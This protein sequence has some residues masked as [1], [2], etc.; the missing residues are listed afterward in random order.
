MLNLNE[1]NEAQR[2]AVMHGEGPLLVL[3]G[4]GSGKTFTITKRIQYLIEE[5]GV[6]SQQILVI[7]FTKAAAQSMQSRFQEQ[8]SQVVPFGTFHSCFYNFL[9]ETGELDPGR[10]WK[11]SKKRQILGQILSAKEG[12]LQ[13]PTNAQMDDLLSLFGYCKN[14]AVSSRVETIRSPLRH[15]LFLALP[16]NWQRDFLQ[17]FQKYEMLRR[18]AGGFD[19]DDILFDCLR[20]LEEK[21]AFRTYWQGR[22]SHIL[23]DEMQD[24]NPIQYAILK[25]LTR[26]PNNLFVVGDDDQSIYG[27]R[28]AKPECLKWFQQDF[29]PKVLVLNVNYRSSAQ[30]V[31]M[32]QQMMKE[33]KE[34]FEKKYYAADEQGT[35]QANSFFHEFTERE[36]MYNYLFGQ[37]KQIPGNETV[38][39]LFRT[40][41]LMQSCARKLHKQGIPFQMKEGGQNPYEHF[42][43]RD[44]FAY[45][46]LGKGIPAREDFLQVM[47]KPLRYLSREAL[48][49]TSFSLE[50]VGRYYEG[51]DPHGNIKKHLEKLKRQ[52]N[53]IKDL[54]LPLAV[55][56]IWKVIG[57]EYYC[58]MEA[59]NN[60]ERMEEYEELVEWL[61][62]EA[63]EYKDWAQWK[64]AAR[65]YTGYAPLSTEG[66]ENIR[67]MTVHGAKGLEFDRVYIPEV[68][69]KVYPKGNLPDQESCE[70][71]RRILYVAMTRAKKSLELLYTVGTKE[72][73]R[74]P[75][76]FIYGIN[77]KQFRQIHSCPETHQTYQIP[78]HTHHHPQ[79]NPTQAPH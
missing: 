12:L 28:G 38:G 45:L 5:L 37:L 62:Q 43:A 6:P 47:N 16:S 65:N 64:E 66:K 1:L 3:A 48:R 60:R 4:P 71:E 63:T 52:L 58:R 76:R 75:S 40:N 70:E 53:Y 22:F 35:M 78:F 8:N 59:G 42:I 11:V 21:P 13:K 14:T 25:L 7:T 34:R 57:Y 79:Y 2:Q 73:P 61:L 77:Q 72:R 68:N 27:F 69:E 56:Y 54:S 50:E 26:K 32:S 49:S 74:L 20:V 46:E 33:S 31:S 24:M 9:K 23:V 67:L 44:I 51:K 17:L 29:Q 41:A 19:Y 18:Q 39:V 10:F 36:Y 55:N 30:I 15:E